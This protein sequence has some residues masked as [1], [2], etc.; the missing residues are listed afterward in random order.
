M[1]KTEGGEV[2]EENVTCDQRRSDRAE[3][4]SLRHYMCHYTKHIHC[5]ACQSAKVRQKR[6]VAR[7]QEDKD[8]IVPT[9]FGEHITMDMLM[10]YTDI[11]AFATGHI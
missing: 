9:M 3:S 11:S 10:L 5:R 2:G 7:R 8:R 1:K 6:Y 4:I